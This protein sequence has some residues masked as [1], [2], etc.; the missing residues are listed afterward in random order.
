MGTVTEQGHGHV[1]FPA[2][3]LRLPDDR[4]GIGIHKNSHDF[5]PLF[6]LKWYQRL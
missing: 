4:T 3:L 1:E 6:L 2:Y 5:S